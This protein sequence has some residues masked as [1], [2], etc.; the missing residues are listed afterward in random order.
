[1]I[2]GSVGIEVFKH[3]LNKPISTM[4][5]AFVNLALP[6][7]VFSEP[8]PPIQNKDK[9][10]DPILLGPVKAIPPNFTIWDKLA[11]KGPLTVGQFIEKFK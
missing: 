4:R 5:N 9:D 3:L 2:V 7:W 8:Q 10:Y 6:F 11:V 1:M